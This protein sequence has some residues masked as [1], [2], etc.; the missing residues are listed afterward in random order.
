M[1]IQ[2]ANRDTMGLVWK[3]SQPGNEN[4]LHLI[5]SNDPDEI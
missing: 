5:D 4:P 2:E 1:N 3:I